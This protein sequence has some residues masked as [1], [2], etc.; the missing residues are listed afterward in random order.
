MR[1][2]EHQLRRIIRQTIIEENKRQ[3]DES[4]MQNIK[5]LSGVALMSVLATFSACNNTPV[6]PAH[7]SNPEQGL[8]WLVKTTPEVPFKKFVRI[9]QDVIDE[10]REQGRNEDADA[11]QD[12]LDGLKRAHDFN[13]RLSGENEQGE[14][15]AP[16]FR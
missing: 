11:L 4:L 15:V 8:E 13:L 2:T 10:L 1:L 9:E 5:K 16:G 6:K 14:I 7:V 3:L 12:L